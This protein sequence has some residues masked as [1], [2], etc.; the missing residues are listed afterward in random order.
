MRWWLALGFAAVAAVTA[1]SVA[2]VFTSRSEAKI[3]ERSR[4]LAAGEALTAAVEITVV[5]RQ[6]IGDAARAL[7]EAR[8]MSIFVL[9]P[10]G[11]LLSRPQVDGIAVRE[12]SNFAELRDTALA[13]RRLVETI[14]EGR[15]VTVALPLR[16]NDRGAMIAV[17]PRS[18]IEDALG[19]VRSEIARAAVL[20]VGIGA[21]VGLLVALLITRR[22]RRIADAAREI[23]GGNFDRELRPRFRDELG[24]LAAT[25]D[26][27]RHHL[28]ESFAAVEGEKDR[29]RRLLEQLQEGVV[30]VDE[31]LRVEFANE[32]ARAILG[33]DLEPGEPLPDPWPSFSLSSAAGQLFAAGA[34]SRAVHVHPSPETSY[35]VALLPP[36]RSSRSGVVVL[37]DVTEQ[38][39]RERAEREFVMNAAHELRTPLAA[40]ASAV[41]AL[42]TGAKDRDEDRD[43][44]LAVV[45]RQ[46]RRLT[47]LTHALLTLARAQTSAE[48][49]KLET[50]AVGLLLHDIADELPDTPTVEICCDD[51]L[52]RAHSDLL[53]QALENLTANALKH[54]GGRGLVLRAAHTRDQR[55]RIS[56]TDGG[57]GM[58]GRDASRAGDRFY[59]ARDADGEGFG[60]GLAI[61]R[62]V[63]G[64]MGGTTSIESTPGSGTTVS[65]MLDAV[66]PPKGC[67]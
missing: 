63:A 54:A 34:S 28:R 43:R 33:S 10:S 36:S 50:V 55:V 67:A 23:E 3:R 24:D 11:K 6:E 58:Q 64:A 39:R 13:G 5:D 46:T 61:V 21:A 8:S 17:A 29:L 59:R 16:G 57:P 35:H 26:G 15:I 14:D 19:I 9:D 45:D 52:V 49:V 1:L 53:R 32:R 20:S 65:V 62:E 25:I 51:L 4:E 38:E 12:L 31:G 41:E 56:V 2:E 60:L 18:E 27:M 22:L 44:F 40:I 30:A 7:G 42:E 48:P 37:T 47:R 66:T